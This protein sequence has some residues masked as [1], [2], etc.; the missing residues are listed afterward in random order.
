LTGES[1]RE[2]GLDV[3]DGSFTVHQWDTGMA[4]KADVLDV[5]SFAGGLIHNGVRQGVLTLHGE[6]EINIEVEESALELAALI[7]NAL[8]L[9][10]YYRATGN[11]NAQELTASDDA[12]VRLRFHQGSPRDCSRISPEQNPGESA[13][14]ATEVNNQT[15]INVRLVS[16][17]EGSREQAPWPRWS[18]GALHSGAAGGA[19]GIFT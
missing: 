18:A 14:G 19:P 9:A 10:G 17:L 4:I 16:D 2:R 12:P 15:D 1:Y 5:A 3:K 6:P 11:S 7:E 8:K 13:S